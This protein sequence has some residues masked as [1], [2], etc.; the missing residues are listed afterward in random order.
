MI[1]AQNARTVAPM[2]KRAKNAPDALMVQ[3]GEYKLLSVFA[4]T[5]APWQQRRVFERIEELAAT[6]EGTADA[7]GVGVLEPIL[8]RRIDNGRYELIDGE[9]RLRAC[10]LIAE[11]SASRDFLVPARVFAVSDRVARLMSQT[12]NVEREAPKPVEVALGY[13]SIRDALCEELGPGAGSVRALEAIGWHKKTMVG[14]YLRIA[15]RVLTLEVLQQAGLASASGEPNFELLCRLE[16]KQ[17]DKIASLAEP[18]AR[19]A[20]LRERVER[21]TTA[22]TPRGLRAAQSTACTPEER[23]A[24]ISTTKRFALRLRAPIELLEPAEAARLIQHEIAPVMLAAT[25]RAQSGVGRE[26]FYSEL[27]SDHTLVVVPVELE[28]LTLQ[29]LEQLA[30]RFGMLRRR[31]DVAIRQ[32]R[33]A[34]AIQASPTKTRV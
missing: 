2:A 10:S 12:A 15:E 31:M 20:T 13:A 25:E 8:V 30:V 29:Q 23:R 16:K 28:A 1:A 11:R 19:A 21:L 3:A 14:D 4:I 17:L 18:S 32:R 33:R 24:E 22:P 34:H 6:I 9:R 5:A 7:E 26:G 27:A